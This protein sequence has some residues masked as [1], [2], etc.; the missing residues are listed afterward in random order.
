M[1]MAQKMARSKGDRSER[2][3]IRPA[4]NGISPIVCVEQQQSF[5]VPPPT[6]C[7]FCRYSDALPVV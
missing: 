6:S 4:V 7:V 2:S 5:D 3:G 1:F